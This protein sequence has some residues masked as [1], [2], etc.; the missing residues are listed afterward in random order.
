MLITDTVD[1]R[2]KTIYIIIKESIHQENMQSPNVCV[3]TNTALKDLKQK[4][5]ESKKQMDKYKII[6]GD[7]NT[8]LSA[9]GRP[10]RHKISRDRGLS[11]HQDLIDMD[12]ILPTTTE[13]T[14]LQCSKSIYQDSP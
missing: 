2:A 7:F 4:L 3:Q 13:Y 8:S 14:F 6:V 11:N 1:F 9:T 5:I 12:I 10:T